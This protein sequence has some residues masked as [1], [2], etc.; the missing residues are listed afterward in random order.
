MESLKQDLLR[1][2]PLAKKVPKLEDY[3]HIYTVDLSSGEHDHNLEDD[4]DE[5]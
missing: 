1:H 4:S 5:Q 3:P 2:S